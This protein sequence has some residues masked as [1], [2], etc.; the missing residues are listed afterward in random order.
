MPEVEVYEV[1]CLCKLMLLSLVI[2]ERDWQS[3]GM[4]I[5]LFC[6]SRDG[7]EG[8]RGRKMDENEERFV[9]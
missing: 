1:L 4:P 5:V 7:G 8:E 3:N 2:V 9:P 6:G